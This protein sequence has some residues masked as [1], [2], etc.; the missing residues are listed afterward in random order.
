MRSSARN[1]IKGAITAI[2]KGATTAHVTVEIAG[3]Q[4]IIASITNEAV[5]DLGLQKGGSATVVIKAS[6]VMIGVS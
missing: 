2:A 4:K 1:Q 5:E 3:G 6:D